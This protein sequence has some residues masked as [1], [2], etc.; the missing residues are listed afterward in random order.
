MQSLLD[1]RQNNNISFTNSATVLR[2]KPNICVLP[3]FFLFGS[4][5]IIG[6]IRSDH[7]NIPRLQSVLL[8]NLSSFACI[9]FTYALFETVLDLLASFENLL[10]LGSVQLFHLFVERQLQTMKSQIP[11]PFFRFSDRDGDFEKSAGQNRQESPSSPF[12]FE[13]ILS[14]KGGSQFE[15]MEQIGGTMSCPNCFYANSR[16]EYPSAMC[17]K[18]ELMLTQL[19]LQNPLC[20][21]VQSLFPWSRFPSAIIYLITPY[22]STVRLHTNPTVSLRHELQAPLPRFPFNCWLWPRRP[23]G[24]RKKMVTQTTEYTWIQIKMWILSADFATFA[25]SSPPTCFPFSHPHPLC[26]R[27]LPILSDRFRSH[28]MLMI[29]VSLRVCTLL[30]VASSRVSWTCTT[31]TWRHDPCLYP[32]QNA[33]TTKCLALRTFVIIRRGGLWSEDLKA[34]SYS[35]TTGK[36]QISV[37]S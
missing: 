30:F 32:P 22:Q 19:I 25:Y 11:F 35:K 1:P 36:L 6:W 24:T 5:G 29:C 3:C 16:T 14:L 7:R 33:S 28:P 15:K 27:S 20:Q 9:R 23:P 17:W 18:F 31:V 4:V 26:H 12:I 21:K 8:A 10:K 2:I 37:T 13:T 34:S